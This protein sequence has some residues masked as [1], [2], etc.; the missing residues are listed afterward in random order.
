MPLLIL[1]MKVFFIQVK[2]NALEAENFLENV[3]TQSKQ[4]PN[5]E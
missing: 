1:M 4:V 3:K 2:S 5:R